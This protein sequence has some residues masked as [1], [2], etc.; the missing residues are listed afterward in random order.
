MLAVP[1]STL[2]NTECDPGCF[3]LKQNWNIHPKRMPSAFQ[4][5]KRWDQIRGHPKFWET[6]KETFQSEHPGTVKS[7]T[8]FKL[9]NYLVLVN[10]LWFFFFLLRSYHVIEISK[11][12]YRNFAV[13]SEYVLNVLPFFRWLIFELICL[14]SLQTAISH[15]LSTSKNKIVINN[16]EICCCS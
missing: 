12:E 15:R 14:N 6:V 2:Q 10:A 3:Q 11:I 13:P 9:L 5:Q 7:V 4:L 8:R 16:S 1:R